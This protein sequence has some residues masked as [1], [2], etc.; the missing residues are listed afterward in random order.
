MGQFEVSQRAGSNGRQLRG[1]D[2]VDAASEDEPDWARAGS[3]QCPEVLSR[4]IAGERAV[5]VIAVAEGPASAH[6]GSDGEELGDVARSLKALHVEAHADDSVGGELRSLLFHALHRK[7]ARVIQRAREHG[8]LVAGSPAP[9]LVAHVIDRA[10]ENQ[11]ERSYPASS[12]SKY[13][14]TVRSD[15]NR[16]SLLSRSRSRPVEPTL[17]TWSAWS[18]TSTTEAQHEL[19]RQRLRAGWASHRGA[20]RVH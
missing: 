8:Q 1:G 13:S 4:E 18:G 17:G 12:R 7:F 6:R 10:T 3:Q 2:A 15:V 16:P 20:Q 14:L 5:A 9:A 19:R 11:T